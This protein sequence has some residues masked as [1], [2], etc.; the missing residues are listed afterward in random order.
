MTPSS[1]VTVTKDDNS[2]Q[3]EETEQL[4][5]ES[6]D[7]WE[8]YSSDD[9]DDDSA[10]EVAAEE[11]SVAIQ[12]PPNRKNVG[13]IDTIARLQQS[14]SAQGTSSTVEGG[15]KSA[16]SVSIDDNVKDEAQSNVVAEQEVDPKKQDNEVAKEAPST[17]KDNE[18]PVTYEAI[19]SETMKVNTETADDKAKKCVSN[20]RS[21]NGSFSFN[22]MGTAHSAS[23][24]GS[25]GCG[26]SSSNAHSMNN[27][28]DMM[29]TDPPRKILTRIDNIGYT[30]SS[31]DGSVSFC[32]LIDDCGFE[33]V[34]LTNLLYHIDDHAGIQWFG[35]CYSCNAQIETE[36]V[37][38]MMEFRHM[39]MA[40]Y[41]KK[42]EDDFNADKAAN[43]E[44]PF[45][46][47]K[48]LP[49]DKLSKLKEEEIAAQAGQLQGRTS[50]TPSTSATR[51]RFIKI[52]S[53]RGL[54]DNM[55]SLSATDSQPKIDA[56]P[57]KEPAIPIAKETGFTIANVVSLGSTSREYSDTELV[58]LK[59]WVNKPTNK[60][61]KNC[62]KMLRDICLYA[63]YKCMDISC[64]FSTDNPDHMLIHLRNHENNMSNDAP[65]WL[66]CAYCDI[67]A[68]S[69]QT[70]VK[71]IQE[72]HQSSIFQCP[73]CF[74]RTCAAFNVVVHLKLYHSNE[75]K[76]VL[77]CNGK[78]RLYQTEKTFIEKSRKENIR[79][80]RCTEGKCW[81][82]KI[83]IF[84]ANPEQL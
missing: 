31:A 45:I 35:Y 54:T 19:V 69:C 42:D 52:T 25:R 47:C 26:G 34:D 16:D 29:D 8:S 77:V 22:L 71:H 40:H 50:A 48:L 79:P 55:K 41:Q 24:F 61:Q 10:A 78:P 46:K 82:R 80:L 7:N 74:Y 18:D 32:C 6:D 59:E 58:S 56:R 44:K 27:D 9:S 3:A 5:D 83:S 39:T 65:S 23:Q 53:V 15:D 14:I 51:S 81:K 20:G 1:P 76:S 75:K 33:S 66:E 30:R 84:V 13:I 36:Q 12:R 2:F 60:L 64:A 63:L 17:D 37:Q 57:S 4:I 73:Y 38:L 49:G 28:V 72:E 43:E 21:S 11:P 68:D 67:L 70:L 62:K